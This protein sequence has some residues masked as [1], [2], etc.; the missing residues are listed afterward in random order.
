LVLELSS[1]SKNLSLTLKSKQPIEFKNHFV[2][3]VLKKF[4]VA[5]PTAP[6]AVIINI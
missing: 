4:G 3:T 5:I 6:T 1:F 2:S